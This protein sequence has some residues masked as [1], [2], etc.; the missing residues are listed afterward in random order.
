[1]NEIINTIL[2]RRSIRKF[3]SEQIKDQELREILNC[4]IHAPSAMNR[5]KWHF[6]VLRNRELMDKMVEVIKENIENSSLEFLK[7]K[8]RS[9]EFHTFYHAPT[10]IVISGKDGERWME[11]DC[12][13]AV[14][15]IILSAESLNINSCVIASSDLLFM[16]EKGRAFIKDIGIPEGYSHICTVAL[17]YKEGEVSVPVKNK[18]V[19]NFVE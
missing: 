1:M 19:V 13:L 8:A 2:K 17:G 4:A 18:D 14:Q 15:N 7:E 16:S 9:P 12:G 5:Q 6:S 3:R 11:L 10:V